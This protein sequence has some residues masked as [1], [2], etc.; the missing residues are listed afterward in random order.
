MFCPILDLATRGRPE[1]EVKEMMEDLINNYF[2]DTGTSAPQ[3]S[4][5]VC[6]RIYNQ[7]DQ[8]TKRRI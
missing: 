8:E 4:D 2:K 7:T 5:S 1:K 3:R 6:H